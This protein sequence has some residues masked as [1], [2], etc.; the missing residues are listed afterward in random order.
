MVGFPRPFVGSQPRVNPVLI[1]SVVR[2]LFGIRTFTFDGPINS[3]G[4]VVPELQLSNDGITWDAPIG[5]A[6][7]TTNTLSLAYLLPVNV[8]NFFRL[9]LRPT[10]IGTVARPIEVIQTGP[11]T[12]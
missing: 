3:T 8:H 5:F 6:A 9:L 7:S 1:T 2:N 12:G 11:V 4:D 10:G